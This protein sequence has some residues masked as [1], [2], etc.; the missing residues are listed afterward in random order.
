MI[1][2]PGS[3]ME[4]ELPLFRKRRDTASQ[5]VN[6]RLFISLLAKVSLM[7]IQFLEDPAQP[8]VKIGASIARGHMKSLSS[9]HQSTQITPTI[10]DNKSS[11]VEKIKM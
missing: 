7:F 4:R 5:Q 6:V 9:P 3:L 1:H 8:A 10:N 2:A 11:T